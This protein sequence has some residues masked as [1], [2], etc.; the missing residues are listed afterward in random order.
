MGRCKATILPAISLVLIVAAVRAPLL[1][2]P[3]ERD[4]GE[5]AYIAW[6]LGYNE[7][8]YRDWVDQKPPA[9]FFIYRIA[10]RLPLEP[11]RAI[12]F[13]A[14]LFSAA[15][16]CALF[17]LGLQFIDRFW[18]FLGAALFALLSSDPL[19]QG[20]AANTELF[21]LCPLILS[22]IA[23]FA[24]AAKTKPRVLFMVLAGALTGIAVMF[25][26]VAVVNWFLL[27]GLYPV[28]APREKRWTGAVSFI[29]W[30]AMGLLTVLA[31]V[32]LYFWRRGGLT[33]F[34]DNVFTH[35]LE[36]IGSIRASARLEYCGDTL[37]TL[38][39]TQAVAWVFAAAGLLVLFMTRRAKWFLLV[40]GWLLTSA[41]GV[42]ASGYFFP[43]YF[44]QL[45]PSLALAA[46]AGAERFAAIPVW[47]IFPT[48]A[49]R[50][51][52]SIVLAVLPAITLWPFLFKYTPAESVRKI[53]PG[54]FFAEMPELARRIESLT[55][56][57]KPVFIFGAEPELLF[58]ARRPSATRYIFLFPLYG[59]YGSVR[60]K[61][62]SAAIE[63]EHARP[64][65]AV[66]LPNA[67]FFV[68]GTDQYFTQWSMSYL[69]E[70]FYADTWLIADEF[71][72][73]R[74][75]SVA[76]GREADPLTAGEQLIGAI[77]VRKLISAP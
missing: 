21:M 37:R 22:L 8:P 65:T 11:I 16:V 2:I 14:L 5:Y 26:Q 9:V 75:E 64:S 58:Y 52:L 1:S 47:K 10:L 35:N 38:A 69:Q 41:I 48:W 54:N 57:E 24:A 56:P 46:A 30:S 72:V 39:R 4:E 51:A 3:L 76:P 42:S 23:F 66:Y 40:A 25:K 77:L 6:R 13:V 17:F 71:S 74:I 15:S 62:T 68:S 29:A 59:P 73:A 44:Q 36:Y 27:A 49:R 34:V 67:L 31:L 60:E 33:D 28:F 43:H 63:I 12:H 61:Q 19:V 45:L 18:A 32:V 53:Y 55:P 7:L 70:N 50:T 20:T